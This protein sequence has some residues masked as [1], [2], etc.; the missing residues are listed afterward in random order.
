MDTYP[1][2]GQA[3]KLSSAQRKPT[4]EPAGTHPPPTG[5]ETDTG[6]P[7]QGARLRTV[8]M[9]GSLVAVGPLTTDMYLPALP[10]VARQLDTSAASVQ[11]TLTATLIGLA[12]GQLVAGPMSDAL[13]R[14]KPLLIG[15]GVHI[16]ASALCAVAPNL[17]VLDAL[18][19]L[20]GLGAATS[21][22]ITMAMVRD[23]YEGARAAG[24]L[25]RLMLVM[26]VAPILAPTFGGVVLTATSWRGVF[27]VL[28]A[29]SVV[30]TVVTARALPETLPAQRRRS[31]GL[32]Q[33]MKDYATL[34]RDRRFVGLVLVAGLA[35]STIF[36]FVAG[37]PFVFQDHFGLDEQEFG[38]VFGA[39]A[40]WVVLATQLNVRVLRRRTP[41]QVLVRAGVVATAGGVLLVVCG[42]TGAGGIVGVLAPLW[43]TLFATGF[44]MPNAPALAL[45]RHGRVAGTAAALLG[46]VQFGIGALVSP[47]VGVVGTGPAAMASVITGGLVVLLLVLVVLVRPGRPD[48]DADL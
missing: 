30:I 40:L 17:A 45:S 33:S 31:G 36:A 12:L 34:L 2:S 25:S 47:L 44:A 26:G 20:Q 4:A 38:L 5:S 29:L 10:A 21:T 18:R 27:V 43:L 37:S 1:P 41:M 42:A 8:L 15:L 16:V 3:S 7:T 14:R 6:S 13:G 24:L 46:A 22:V 28:A 11:L 32:G 9:L 19:M 48:G 35:M 23:L 39:G